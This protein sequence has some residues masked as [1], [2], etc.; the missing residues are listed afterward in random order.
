MENKRILQVLY[1]FGDS[2]VRA[3]QTSIDSKKVNASYKL[4]QSIDYK[5]RLLGDSIE[6]KLGWTGDAD[7]YARAADTGRRPGKMPPIEP[8][9]KWIAAKGIPLPDESALRKNIRRNTGG[10]LAGKVRRLTMKQ[11][12]VEQRSKS[13]AFL[14]ARK[15]GKE[16]TKASNFFT[17]VV[18]DQLYADLRKQLAAA[19]KKDIL[20]ELRKT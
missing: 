1:Q 3:L 12:S 19:A 17:D 5:V 7:G 16:G 4:R 8:I 18:T 6:F 9:R 15:I 13:L 11:R 20:I 14:I 2:T 10:K